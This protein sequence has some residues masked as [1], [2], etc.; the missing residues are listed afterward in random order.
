MSP[1]LPV[2]AVAL[3]TSAPSVYPTACTDRVIRAIRP[4]LAP[5]TATARVFDPAFNRFVRRVTDGATGNASNR[6]FRLPS[7][8]NACAWGRRSDRFI[9]LTTG[10]AT[11]YF[12]FDASTGQATYVMD[13]ST[14]AT[15]PSW[16]RVQPSVIYDTTQGGSAGWR[17]LAYDTEANLLTTLLDLAQI[18]PAYAVSGLYFGGSIQSSASTPERLVIFY[19]GSGQDRHF[20]VCVFE[21]ANPANRIVYDTVARTLN[22]APVTVDF[23][24]HVHSVGLD[25]SGQYVIVYPTGGDI[26]AGAAQSYV[27]TL[28]TGSIVGIRKA[29]AGHACDGYGVHVN[30]DGGISSPYDADQWVYRSLAS[31]DTPAAVIAPTLTPALVYAS[32]HTQYNAARADV[33]TPFVTATYRFNEDTPENLQTAA[34]ARVNT[35]PWRAWDNEILSVH[36]VSG[37]VSR[38]GHHHANIYADDGSSVSASFE[39]QPMAQ[40]SPDG[41]WILFSS[42]WMKTLGLDAGSK[43]AA[44]ACRTDLFLID[45]AE[46]PGVLVTDPSVLIA[47]LDA[48]D[49]AIA[50]LVRGSSTLRAALTPGG[51]A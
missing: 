49:A 29:G 13:L 37:V 40:I 44:I 32:D 2:P 7:S 36:P 17:V 35:V 18:D 9:A 34:S 4:V 28:A 41:R 20:R 45:T 15:E 51:Q 27:W 6:S 8:E 31:V 12:T 19:G 47:Q 3:Q 26:T 42:N 10:G 23:P 50:G 38:W 39:Y 33:V 22:G 48:I 21:A 43:S 11:K 16:S 1:T 30:K 5:A 25:Q 24:F 46:A 14:F